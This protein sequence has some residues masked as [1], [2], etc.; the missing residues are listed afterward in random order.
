MSTGQRFQML[1]TR[2]VKSEDGVDGGLTETL[3]LY[4]LLF[5]SGTTTVAPTAE[6][7]S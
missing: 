2:S 3:C 7:L 6:I 4:I 1:T 5:R